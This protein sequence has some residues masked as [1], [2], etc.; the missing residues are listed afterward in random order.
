MAATAAG[1]T[2]IPGSTTTG[3]GHGTV[4]GQL[5]K[6]PITICERP[7]LC[8]QRK[9][10]V[11]LPS[12]CRPSTLASGAQALPREALGHQR[13]ELRDCRPARE[14]VE[15]VCRKRSTVSRTEDLLN[16]S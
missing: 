8:T 15:R 1:F 4:T 11:G 7:A 13:Q 6:K 10:T 9:S 3:P 5:L 2:L 14:L 16:S 12:P